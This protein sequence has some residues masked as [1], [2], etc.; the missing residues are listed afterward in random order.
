[1]IPPLSTNSPPINCKAMERYP[2]QYWPRF[3]PAIGGRVPGNG[4][5][6][7]SLIGSLVGSVIV[8]ARIVSQLELP[9]AHAQIEIVPHLL[10]RPGFWPAYC[11]A[12]TRPILARIPLHNAQIKIV[13]RLLSRPGFWPA[14][15]LAKTRPTWIPLHTKL[16]IYINR[17]ICY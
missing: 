4:P 10:S 5:P 11:R 7:G 8:L 16:F 17:M 1:M 3:G 12:K 15:C 13:S 2:C 9:C 14:Y 6:C